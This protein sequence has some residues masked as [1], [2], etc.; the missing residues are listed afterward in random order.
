[1]GAFSKLL[2]PP[3]V[4]AH[5]PRILPPMQRFKGVTSMFAHLP[6]SLIMK[7]VKEADGG[8]NTHK[9][10]IKKVHE[11]MFKRYT[12]KVHELDEETGEEQKIDVW[13]LEYLNGMFSTQQTKHMSIALTPADAQIVSECRCAACLGAV[14][15]ERCPR[16][17]RDTK[18]LKKMCYD[19]DWMH[20][21]GHRCSGHGERFIPEEDP[22][23]GGYFQDLQD[24]TWNLSCD[25]RT[26][27][28]STGVDL[29][30]ERETLLGRIDPE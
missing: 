30:G 25:G 26:E 5:R 17:P 10:N 27:N 4:A 15:L 19:D 9:N 18:T 14:T 16:H 28:Y 24:D 8:I 22:L 6:N 3:T 29:Y 11:E 23:S 21:H 12:V 1:M 2:R 20:H 13:G 7:I